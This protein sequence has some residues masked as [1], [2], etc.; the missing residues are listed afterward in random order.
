KS[1]G[2]VKIQTATESFKRDG[3]HI[4]VLKLFQAAKIKKSFLTIGNFYLFKD[5]YLISF[6]LISVIIFSNSASDLS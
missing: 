2:F 5:F 6:S 1:I 4:I 3:F